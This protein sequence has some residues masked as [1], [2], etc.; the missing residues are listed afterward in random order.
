MNQVLKNKIV[1]VAGGAGLLGGE[2]IR[3]I[4]ANGGVAVIADLNREAEYQFTNSIQSTDGTVDFVTCDINDKASILKVIQTVSD[5]YGK[6]DALV[7]SAYPRN[8]N[9][10]R[11]L[12]EVAYDDFCEN[13]NLNL[14]G[15]F[16]A[17]QQFA[18]YFI[19]QGYGNIVNLAS[20]Y[21]VV[22]PK[23]EIYEGTTMTMP[24]EYAVIKSAIIH[25]TKYF[26]KSLKGKKIRINSLSPGGILDNQPESFISA[27]RET[28]LNKGMLDKADLS[29][30]LIY[31]LSD[32]SQYVNGQNLI[33]DDGFT[34]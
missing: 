9:Y 22:A 28:C 27:Y 7:N 2:F 32:A 34:L 24:V 14:G 12:L 4:A 30:P 13:I 17:S 18:A 26:A 5:K 31:L 3:A 15:Y 6:I 10:G 33:V 29:G 16:L 11:K 20:I 25:L 21:G 23:F 19:K 8:K 1:V